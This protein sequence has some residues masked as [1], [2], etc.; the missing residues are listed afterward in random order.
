MMQSFVTGDGFLVTSI[1]DKLAGTLAL[2]KSVVVTGWNTAA[3]RDGIAVSIG[4]EALGDV[5]S[6][7]IGYSSHHVLHLQWY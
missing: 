1:D 5:L 7:S 4:A 6:V 3:I 2:G